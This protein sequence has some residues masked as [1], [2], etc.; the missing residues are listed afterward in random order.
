[1][2]FCLRLEPEKTA[3]FQV[4]PVK[5]TQAAKNGVLLD[6]TATSNCP[7]HLRFAK[8]ITAHSFSSF[9]HDGPIHESDSQMAPSNQFVRYIW[10]RFG[11]G[12]EADPHYAATARRSPNA[13]K[14]GGKCFEHDVTK[15]KS[16]SRSGAQLHSC[17]PP[18]DFG[19]DQHA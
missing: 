12:R 16:L 10:P 9:T 15:R 13:K 17:A 11:I 2:F 8:T 1:M 18:S 3:L 19:L 5:S 14:L 4:L 7:T 6:L